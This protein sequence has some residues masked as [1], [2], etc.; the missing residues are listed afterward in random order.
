MYY[1]R[2]KIKPK[3]TLSEYIQSDQAHMIG[4][5]KFYSISQ[6]IVVDKVYLLENLDSAMEDLYHLLKLPEIPSLP[7][8]KM[9]YRK[10]KRRYRDI[11][12]RSDRDM[13]RKVFARELLILIMNFELFSCWI[14][15]EKIKNTC[16]ICTHSSSPLVSTNFQP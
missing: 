15:F 3:P 6:K 4:S 13:I 2:Y 8:A 9:G 1:Y 14:H 16:L 12:S 10:D 7:N 5:F 11:L